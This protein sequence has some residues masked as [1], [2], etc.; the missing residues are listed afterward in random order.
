MCAQIRQINVSSVKESKETNV[1]LS[2]GMI[3]VEND[4]WLV[5]RGTLAGTSSLWVSLSILRKI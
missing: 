2:I 5:H 4:R 1:A 3:E